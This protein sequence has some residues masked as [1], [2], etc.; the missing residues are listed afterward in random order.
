MPAPDNHIIEFGG[1]DGVTHDSGVEL[2][3]TTFSE[4]FAETDFTMP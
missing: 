3:D 2:D 4:L 1:N